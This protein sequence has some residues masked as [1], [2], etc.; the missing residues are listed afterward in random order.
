MSAIENLMNETS[1]RI[2]FYV[3]R[4]KLLFG[5]AQNSDEI[6][7]SI[8]IVLTQAIESLKEVPIREITIKGENEYIL[9][10]LRGK[11]IFGFVLPNEKNKEDIL[12]I[13]HTREE[14]IFEELFPKKKPEVKVE[15]PK[16]IEKEEKKI[17]EKVEAK[18]EKIVLSADILDKI[19]DISTETLGD[20]ASEIFENILNDL[21]INK[22]NLNKDKLMELVNE[23]E[24]SAKMIVGPTKAGNMKDD[25]LKHLKEV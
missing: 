16:K 1:S 24:K 18:E 4:K 19:R 22:D 14:E 21:N 17:E 23:L 7:E 2:I 9:I 5:D 25:I 3:G 11:E 10:I 6:L 20:F 13:Y 8:S 12:R 15:E